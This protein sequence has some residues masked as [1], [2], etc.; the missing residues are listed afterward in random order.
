MRLLHDKPEVAVRQKACPKAVYRLGVLCA[1]FA[2]KVVNSNHS[3]ASMTPDI[4]KVQFNI[5]LFW[6]K[7]ETPLSG[8]LSAC[9][10]FE[11]SAENWQ[12]VDFGQQRK[13]MT[14]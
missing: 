12:A 13:Q 8:A 7:S 2:V 4:H 5:D 11:A 1:S 10:I 6:S 9:I 14:K 3:S